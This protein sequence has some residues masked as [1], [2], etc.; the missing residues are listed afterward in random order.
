MRCF[1]VIS[2]RLPYHRSA[3][4]SAKNS[5]HT[6]SSYNFAKSAGVYD[7]EIGGRDALHLSRAVDHKQR[8]TTRAGR[9]DGASGLLLTASRCLTRIIAVRFGQ[10]VFV[11][12]HG[13]LHDSGLVRRQAHLATGDDHGLED[14]ALGKGQVSR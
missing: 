2:T 5:C 3:S 7:L 14:P 1:S 9:A 4:L 6:V 11:V 8:R 13:Q 10:D 12:H